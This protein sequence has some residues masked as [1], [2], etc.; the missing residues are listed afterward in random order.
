MRMWVFGW[1]FGRFIAF[2]DFLFDIYSW[3]LEG[4]LFAVSFNELL[5]SI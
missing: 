3:L 5:C 4:G 2:V 1:C